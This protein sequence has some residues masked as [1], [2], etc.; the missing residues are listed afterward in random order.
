MSDSQVMVK[1]GG[2]ASGASAAA[3]L[4]AAN[5]VRSSRQ[6]QDSF[7]SVTPVLAELQSTLERMNRTAQET[8]DNT[9]TLRSYANW[10]FAIKAV[11]VAY[12]GIAGAAGLAMSGV[13][14]SSAGINGL[15]MRQ[16]EAVRSLTRKWIDYAESSAYVTGL[17]TVVEAS[18]SGIVGSLGRMYLAIDQWLLR[19]KLYDSA[20]TE[21]ARNNVLMSVSFEEAERNAQKN[22]YENLT[23]QIIGMTAELMKAKTMTEQTASTLAQSF[24]SIPDVTAQIAPTLQQ[25]VQSLTATDDEAKKLGSSLASAFAHPEASQAYV[26][27]LKGVSAEA[28]RAYDDALVTGEQYKI[29]AALIGLMSEQ[30]HNAQ[31]AAVARKEEERQAAGIL[32][33]VRD[34]I[35]E[36]VYAMFGWKTEI[37]RVSEAYNE[38]Q[39]KLQG[40]QSSVESANMSFERQQ[41]RVNDIVR[42]ANPLSAQLAKVQSEIA[43]LEKAGTGQADIE[44]LH[45]KQDE[46]RRILDIRRGGTALQLEQQRARKEELED[47]RNVIAN[48]DKQIR[49]QQELVAKIPPGASHVREENTLLELQN[50][51]RQKANDILREKMQLE[52]QEAVTPKEKYQAGIRSNDAEVAAARGD[53]VRILQLK[54]E[55]L[56][57]E[58]ELER[59]NQQVTKARYDSEYQME[60]TALEKRKTLL[61]EGVETGKITR[62]Q[63]LIGDQEIEGE[64]TEIERRHQ[65][66]LLQLATKGTAEYE[67]IAQNLVRIDEEASARRLAVWTKDIRAIEQQYQGLANQLGGSLTSSITGVITGTQKLGAAFRSVATSIVN[68]FVKAGVDMVMNWAAKQAAMVALTTASQASQTAAITAG[69]A[70]QNAAVAAGAATGTAIRGA[71]AEAAIQSDAALTFGGIFA[72]LSSLMGPAAAG[73]AATGMATVEAMAPIAAMDI[74]AWSIPSDQL[75]MVHKNELVMPAAQADAFRNLLSRGDT[76]GASGGD[77]HL[78]IHAVDAQSVHALFKSNGRALAA[79]LRDVMNANPSLR[80]SY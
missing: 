73:P 69:Q 44:T 13:M 48:L 76:G 39:T 62:M 64:R 63:Q 11:Q 79:T 24:L 59:N 61:R 72:F 10:A 41:Q 29:Q 34:K 70:A 52:K 68:M 42:A 5:V 56:Q 47:Q 4:A 46:E 32:G 45:Q 51:R 31:I 22:G 37:Q 49:M 2:D 12:D 23:R 58:Q 8:A 66:K 80:P 36:N 14:N 55:R 71:T 18:S 9:G 78:H 53:Q 17:G 7:A 50:V 25:V 67:T 3:N 65:Q 30:M 27:T 35:T 40:I 28:R 26:N 21:I 74:G 43:A 77:T 16:E 33:N 57:L 75:A 60:L 54:R 19:A 6:M 38:L 15:L 1:F 20:S